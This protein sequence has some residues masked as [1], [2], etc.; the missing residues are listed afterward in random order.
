MHSAGS[1][2]PRATAGFVRILGAFF[3]LGGGLLMS[4]GRGWYTNGVIPMQ[5]T[6]AFVLGLGALLEIAPE[7]FR[8][9]ASRFY[10]LA[11]QF[12]AKAQPKS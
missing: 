5:W 7:R 3:I 6:G 10:E 8:R 11:D 4:V 12:S 1:S 9:R 2:E